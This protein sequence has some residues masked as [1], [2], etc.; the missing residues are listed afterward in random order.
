MFIEKSKISNSVDDNTFH[1]VEKQF[2]IVWNNFDIAHGNY[3]K[4]VLNEFP[5]SM[6]ISKN[7]KSSLWLINSKAEAYLKLS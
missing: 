3:F 2:P 7:L 5:K 6:S 1:R 4:V